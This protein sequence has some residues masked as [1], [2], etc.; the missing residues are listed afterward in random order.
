MIAGA[1]GTAEATRIQAAMTELS[2]ELA[3]SEADVIVLFTPHGPQLPGLMTIVTTDQV[4]GALS[5]PYNLPAIE[6][7]VDPARLGHVRLARSCDRALSAN[8]LER[9]TAARLPISGIGYGAGDDSVATM[10]M[11][12]ATLIPL[13]L[14]EGEKHGKPL[15]VVN[16]SRTVDAATHVAGGGCLAEAAELLGRRV[17]VIASGDHGQT[18]SADGPFGLDAAAQEY[19]ALVMSCFAGG[20]LEPLLDPA[21]EAL[22]RRACADSWWPMLGLHGLLSAAGPWSA[23]VL[24]Y[25]VPTYYG[26]ACVQL[27]RA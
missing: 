25:E 21:V 5:D 12:W 18:H 17:A 23:T 9:M 7:A 15:V 27:V 13:W 10:P 24:A 6:A 11:D 16:T 1:A 4:A 19:D 3:A 26:M 2:R 14:L 20:G 8:A 22:V